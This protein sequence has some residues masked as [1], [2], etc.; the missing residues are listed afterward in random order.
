MAHERSEAHPHSTAAEIIGDIVYGGHDG[1]ITTF[2]IIAG[3]VGATLGAATVVILGIA[4]VIADGISMSAS[5]Y[6]SRKSEAQAFASQ[7]KIEEWETVHEPEEERR[8]IRD[9]LESKGYRGEDLE[10]LVDL[11]VK[12]P[13]FWV[14]IMM[15]E[16]LGIP[17]S[18]RDD[19]PRR[20]AI[21][22]F[23]SFVAAGLIPLAPYFGALGRPAAELF[24]FAI[25]SSGIALFLVGI[26]RAIITGR[27]WY[28]STLEVLAVGTFAGGTAYLIGK[29]VARIVGAI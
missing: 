17:G 14:D 22:T 10:R 12:N 26:L 16:E 28:A 1:V 21:I 29:I 18:K 27:R 5:S 23:A 6:L 15:Q 3:S 24:P 9:I 7:K 25:A 2:A 8:E 11:V 20:A 13:K 4:N 19:R